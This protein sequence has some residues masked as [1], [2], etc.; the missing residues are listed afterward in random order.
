MSEEYD[1]S[2]HPAI[3]GL[4]T[5]KKLNQSVLSG[6]DSTSVKINS[7]KKG[8]R[9]QNILKSKKRSKINP[10][11]GRIGDGSGYASKDLAKTK[12]RTYAKKLV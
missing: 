7:G 4:T 8:L 6:V 11:A 12:S 9:K 5:P 10:L 1:N 2:Q 3:V